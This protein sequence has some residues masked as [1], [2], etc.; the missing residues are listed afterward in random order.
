M[1]HSASRDGSTDWP[2]PDYISQTLHVI[3]FL[4]SRYVLDVFLNCYT[5]NLLESYT[6]A[7]AFEYYLTDKIIMVGGK[8]AKR[9][10]ICH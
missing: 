3:D 10:V 4:A 1:E 6:L 9:F 5:L 2:N 7:Y 8:H